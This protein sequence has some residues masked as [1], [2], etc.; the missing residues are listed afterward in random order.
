LVI[1]GLNDSDEEL[2][3]I[4]RFICSV[5][6]RIPWH[7]SQSY[8]AWKMRDRPVT[9]IETLDRARKIGQEAAFGTCTWATSLARE[10]R[11]RAARVAGPS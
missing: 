10:E 8:P 4:A 2:G 5:D 9:S 3:E 1:P 6:P 11:I 7:V